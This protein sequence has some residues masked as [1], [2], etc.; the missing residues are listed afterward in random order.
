MQIPIATITPNYSRSHEPHYEKPFPV[1]NLR[2]RLESD[3]HQ[4]GIL[5][6][7]R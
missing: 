6:E 1:A 4:N 7:R 2:G 5:L 3:K